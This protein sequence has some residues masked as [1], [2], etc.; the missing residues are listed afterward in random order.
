MAE[1]FNDDDINEASD[2][3]GVQT[4]VEAQTASAAA[5]AS[6]TEAG[7]AKDALELQYAKTASAAKSI[8]LRS[9]EV[10]KTD[11]NVARLSSA[12]DSLSSI[13]DTLNKS[14]KTAA[15]YQQAINSINSSGFSSEYQTLKNFQEAVGSNAVAK[16]ANN[17][18]TT[19]SVKEQ[20][21]AL[22]DSIIKLNQAVD[23]NSVTPDMV[24]EV[25]ANARA[26]SAAM[27]AADPN[28]A[29]QAKAK[30]GDKAYELA[31][32]LILIG[33]AV[34]GLFLAEH[35]L[36]QAYS[37]CYKVITDGSNTK[38]TCGD[39]YS[40]DQQNCTCGSIANSSQKSGPITAADCG[41]GTS[42]Y[43]QCNC[44]IG[45]NP[46]CSA[47][48]TQSGAVSYSY[49]NVSLFEAVGDAINSIVSPLADT[50]G[51]GN[52]GK[53]LEYA[54]IGILIIMFLYIGYQLITHFMSRSSSGGTTVSKSFF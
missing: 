20:Q 34:G 8:V 9:I 21:A 39:D 43:P 18:F 54:G 44:G 12:V 22:N 41:P 15:D 37:G 26:A 2:D 45:S 36:E 48:L 32:L 10:V 53:I 13:M 49:R 5:E 31:K 11:A 6:M 47:D 19:D 17:F 52:I 42:M 24:K 1:E 38:L 35:L 51:L 23:T 14:N 27:D 3:S 30:W 4:D 25:T 16:W 28:K 40:N 33:T 46:R 29:E 50:F 7:A